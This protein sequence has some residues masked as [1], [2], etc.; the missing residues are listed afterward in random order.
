MDYNRLDVLS[1]YSLV[2][3]FRSVIHMLT[4]DDVLDYNT[5]G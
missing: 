3:K 2:R 4:G 1:L 5:L